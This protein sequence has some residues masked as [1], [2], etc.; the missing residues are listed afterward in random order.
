MVRHHDV[1]V[2]GI[3]E[4]PSRD[5]AA[6]RENHR[7]AGDGPGRGRRVRAVVRVNQNH[8]LVGEPRGQAYGSV[9]V[10]EN[11][12]ESDPV[13]HVDQREE[14]ELVVLGN[15]LDYVDGEKRR[16]RDQHERRGQCRD[17]HELS[18][19]AIPDEHR[20]DKADESHAVAGH[21]A[22]E[23]PLHEPQKLLVRRRGE[24]HLGKSV[25]Q[26]DTGKDLADA[27]LIDA[28]FLRCLDGGDRCQGG[29]DF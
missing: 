26:V 25:A 19:Q 29:R 27:Q 3:R 21:K 14:P 6:N 24:K 22:M 1:K 23:V 15:E 18:K 13:E 12:S 7:G 9:N 20:S 11:N 8:G 28:S 4:Q 16:C 2:G 17:R 10:L 5:H